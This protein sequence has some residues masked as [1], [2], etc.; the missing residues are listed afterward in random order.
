MIKACLPAVLSVFTIITI[1]CVTSSPKVSF[2]ESKIA[3][4]EVATIN[5]EKYKNPDELHKFEQEVIQELKRKGY[6]AYMGPRTINDEVLIRSAAEKLI[7]NS[8]ADAF[9]IIDGWGGGPEKAKLYES[10]ME[11]GETL[12]TLPMLYHLYNRNREL[13]LQ[14]SER[15]L[16]SQRDPTGVTRKA[17]RLY[18]QPGFVMTDVAYIAISLIIW[19][20]PQIGT[21]K[22][23]ETE[24]E[25][26]S[27]IAAEFTSNI[28]DFRSAP[29]ASGAETWTGKWKVTGVGSSS[30]TLIFKQDTQTVTLSDQDQL[31]ATGVVSGQKLEGTYEVL[32]R[33]FEF[34]FWLSSDAM[35]FEGYAAS[36]NGKEIVR[37]V[38]LE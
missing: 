23:L 13:V 38:R 1:G 9:M 30:T 2:Y 21:Y 37:G 31:K 20:D 27:R 28:P 29:M 19:K 25:F 4:I 14:S 34:S 36:Q 16:W 18:F 11:V 6:T 24:D 10:G 35:S 12:W 26:R 33:D 5:H 32:Q 3:Q 15:F 17:E 22:S 8:K 7:N